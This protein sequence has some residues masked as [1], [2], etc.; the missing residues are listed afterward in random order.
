MVLLK[1]N[2]DENR[3]LMDSLKIEAIPQLMLFSDGK[4]VW[5]HSGLIEKIEVSKAVDKHL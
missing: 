3:V 1:I 5:S 4:M 2:A